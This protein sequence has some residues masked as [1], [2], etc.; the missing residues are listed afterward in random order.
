M[1][2][3][4]KS[5]SLIKIFFFIFLSLNFAKSNKKEEL[6]FNGTNIESDF[7]TFDSINY[8]DINITDGYT[9]KFIRIL[10]RGKD[11]DL[12]INYIISFYQQDSNYQQRTQ[13]AQSLNSEVELLLNT[14][15]ISNQFFFTVECDN[16][17][18]DYMYQINEE[19]NFELNLDE[20]YSYTY[21][22]TNETKEMNFI[23]HGMPLIPEEEI[24]EGNNVITVWAKGNKNIISDLDVDKKEESTEFNAYLVKLDNLEEFKYNFK[25][26]G[27]IGDLINVGVSF[28]DGS[29][30]NFYSN[31]INNNT[32]EFSGFLK[33][34]IKEVNCFKI[35]KTDG[36]EDGFIS[37][38]S[39]NNYDIELM[40]L[41]TQYKDNNYFKRCLSISN[42][43]EGFYSF[44][45]IK[46]NNPKSANIYPP[47]YIGAEYSRYILEG[48][49][50]QLVPITPDYYYE[51]ITY[52]III[53]Q[54][55]KINAFINSCTTYPKCDVSEETI[56]K[57]TKIQR[58]KSFT[59][60]FYKS[61][62]NFS[63]YPLDKKQKILLIQCEKGT[64]SIHTNGAS[65]NLEH[66][67]IKVNMFTD[68][69]KFYIEPYISNYRYI[70]NKNEN[71]FI[72]GSKNNQAEYMVLNIEL[73]S[74]NITINLS[75]INKENIEEYHYNNKYL[76]IIREKQCSLTIKA[77]EN[78]FYHLNYILKNNFVIDYSFIIG[79]N[80]LFNIKKHSF[81]NIILA[82]PNSIY[83]YY[84]REKRSPVFIGFYPYDCSIEVKKTFDINK[85]SIELKEEKEHFYQDISR[86][87]LE[88][89]TIVTLF[90]FHNYTVINK[91]EEDCLVDLSHFQYIAQ[92]SDTSES[93]ILSKNSLKTFK[94]TSNYKVISFSYPHFNLEKEKNLT[95]EFKLIDEG[96]YKINL[97][98][99]DESSEFEYHINNNLSI[100]LKEE[101]LKRSCKYDN[102][103]CKLSFIIETQKEKESLL[104]V[105]I[106]DLPEKEKEET[107]KKNEG[108]LSTFTI[109]IIVL[110]VIIFVGIIVFLVIFLIK[111]KRTKSSDIDFEKSS[112]KADNADEPKMLNE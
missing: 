95:F 58:F 69:D 106:G 109:F 50:I 53:G 75:N 35:E 41:I 36:S 55:K 5:S 96:D 73:L 7:I 3:N 2:P 49:T 89:E 29:F 80:Y 14:R 8:F 1:S 103:V 21:Y 30:H 97:F 107:D 24:I 6:S 31:D 46:K 101:V 77:L 104:Q 108:G 102:Q 4:Y 60:T 48:D 44:Q 61:D 72:I 67:L 91:G 37:Y 105:Q 57:S 98:I 62:I 11:T 25:V 86:I 19:E 100:T 52:H 59:I 64:R 26:I 16:Y 54:G 92:S 56:Q 43:D 65:E 18:C 23:I 42:S 20:R 22:V 81:E 94:F 47:Q 79:A 45:Y 111:R 76:Y 78:S 9:P 85:E 87:Y 93:I 74:G 15:Q 82:N 90:P 12:N 27:E 84:E 63:S 110:A 40:T 68:Q 66:C 71:N 10:I 51:Y 17:P 88:N 39:F 99:N 38:T 112:S 28:F 13:L 33:K 34:G 32:K 70:Q 83:N